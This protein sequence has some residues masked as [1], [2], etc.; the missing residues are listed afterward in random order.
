[1]RALPGLLA[2]ELERLMPENADGEVTAPLRVEVKTS[3]RELR[4][5]VRSAAVRNEPG[6]EPDDIPAQAA[7][8]PGKSG[9]VE[10]LRRSLE[11]ARITERISVSRPQPARAEI[12]SDSPRPRERVDALL[13]LLEAW[14]AAGALDTFLRELPEALVAAWHRVI[15]ATVA[16]GEIPGGE[17]PAKVFGP[18]FAA[19][20]QRALGAPDI[21]RMRL[22][23]LAV[24]DLLSE[25]GSARSHAEICAAAA[26]I[27]LDA[28]DAA[29]RPPAPP[30]SRESGGLRAP[31]G[32]EIQVANT[33]PFLL[34]GPLQRIGWLDVLDSTLAGANL[35]HALASLAL[36]LASKV[37]PEPERGWRRLPATTRAAA[38]FAGDT[39]ARPDAELVSLARAAAPLMPG[40]DAVIR[41]SL[42]DGRSCGDTLMFVTAGELQLVVDPPGVFV[43]AHAD[44]ADA[45]SAP[46][47]EAHSPVFVPEEDAD[48]QMLAKLDAAGVTF[49]TP[50]RP[51]RD[52]CWAPIPNTR[53][54]RLY[55]NRPLQ[56]I[57]SPP[58]G[59]AQRARE[60][61]CAFD[62]RPLPGRPQDAALDRSLSLAAA[63]ALGTLAWELWRTR[64][65]TDPL[66]ALER[67]GDIDGSV[68]FEPHRVRVRLPMGKRFRDLKEAGLLEDIPR[69]PWLDYRTLVF[70]GG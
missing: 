5:W 38:T 45:L 59:A 20:M 3:L 18:R 61:W 31:P 58:P 64:E 7:P 66:L 69:V 53:A 36:A 54:P 28:D 29:V 60:S 21:E 56:R 22:R 46:L 37:L 63:L 27:A 44:H 19:L 1:M 17:S 70:T 41:R 13:K 67:F 4:E 23:L 26:A 57:L 34:L 10:A 51:V 33:L 62:K 50:A 6:A 43:I 35:Q 8:S 65:P 49:V 47:L 12:A 16:R 30:I 48:A 14:R 11:A 52:E 25:A 39:D 68:R 32:F 2:A 9:I 42:L 15:F 24:A 55:S 40:L